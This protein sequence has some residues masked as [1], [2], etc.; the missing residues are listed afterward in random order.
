MSVDILDFK[1]VGK[2]WCCGVG[3]YGDYKMCE[4]C[5]EHC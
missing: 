5:G 3:T 4:K 1:R 2:S